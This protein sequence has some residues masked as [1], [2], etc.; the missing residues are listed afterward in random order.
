MPISIIFFIL[1]LIPILKFEEGLKM[2]KEMRAHMDDIKVAADQAKTA[3]IE[4]KQR[5]EAAETKL[6]MVKVKT[7]SAM[8]VAQEANPT[9]MVVPTPSHQEPPN[10]LMETEDLVHD[11]IPASEKGKQ[12]VSFSPSTAMVLYN[13]EA[14]VASQLFG[15]ILI[16]YAF[17]CMR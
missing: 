9:G 7:S 16:S 17:F 11:G 5:A 13:E 6:E 8:E 10:W 14:S 4:A 12:R 1:L 2:M 15:V 3:Y